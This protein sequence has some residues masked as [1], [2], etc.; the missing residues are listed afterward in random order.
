MNAKLKAI[1]IT[2]A[3]CF[4]LSGAIFAGYRTGYPAG[5]RAGTIAG[6]A[7]ERRAI[8]QT[9]ADRSSDLSRHL[10]EALRDATERGDRM[11]G[12][13]RG[14]I[15]ASRGIAAIVEQGG[16]RAAVIERIADEIDRLAGIIEGSTRPG[17]SSPPGQDEGRSSTD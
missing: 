5:H 7:A 14:A 8:E 12:G 3:F 4:L 13:I 16:S 6:A 1:I 2:V 15:E 10:A 17:N 9:A 11:E